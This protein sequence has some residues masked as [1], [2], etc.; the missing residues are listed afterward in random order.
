MITLLDRLD[1]EL[2][3]WIFDNL[4]N[5]FFDQYIPYLRI[6]TTW[7]PFFILLAFFLY[8]K[9]DTKSFLKSIVL[10]TIIILLSDQIAA[11]VLKPIILRPRPC[12]QFNIS[13]LVDCGSGYSMPSAHAANFFALS[14][15]ILKFLSNKLLIFIT[16]ISAVIVG[17]SQIYVGVHFPFDIV[18]GAILGMVI[19]KVCICIYNYIN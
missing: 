14:Y 13:I 10:L 5:T 19:S 17:L 6:T 15:F 11:H 18:A 16:F 12:H 7:I 1:K 8:K 9:Y 2:Y 3:V 4:H